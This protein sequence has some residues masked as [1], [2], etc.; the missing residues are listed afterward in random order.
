MIIA[1]EGIDAVGKNTQ[2][3]LLKE[4]AEK[5]GLKVETLSFPRY[6]ETIFA[7]SIG[8]YLNGHFGGLTDIPPH[9][10]A[11]LYAGDRLES[12]TLITKILSS[13]D[14]L[15]IDRYVCSNLAY[16]SAKVSPPNREDFINW[17]A[18]IEYDIYKL[19]EADITLYLD[20]PVNVASQLLYKKKSRSYTTDKADIHERNLE[21]LTE[22]RRVYKSLAA[23]N[24]RS[25]WITVDCSD[26]GQSVRDAI[27]I[28][29]SVWES[30]KDF[31]AH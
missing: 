7:K 27:D 2:T 12:L 29:Q 13:M 4:Q 5:S 18:K 16:Q 11:L 26:S 9:F 8:K 1:I 25:Q 3:N 30:I 21:Y 24:F 15:I 28:H 22:C 19:P 23:R 17:L 14:L 31:V 20:L 6:N 10:P